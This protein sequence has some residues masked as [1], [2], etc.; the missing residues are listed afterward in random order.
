MSS[1]IIPE[2]P[3]YN[4]NTSDSSQE[5]EKAISKSIRSEINVLGSF[6]NCPNIIRLIAYCFS[7][8]SS[9]DQLCLVYEFAP[10]GDLTEFMKKK[11]KELLWQYR[12]RIAC[13]IAT[14]LNFLHMHDPGY[15]AFHRDIKSSNIVLM[16]D[17]SPK[18]ID[19]G[20]S[21]YAPEGESALGRSLIT[22]STGGNRFGTPAYMCPEYVRNR[23]IKYDAKC[24]FYSF[25]I[26]LLELLSGRQQGLD[27]VY[28]EDVVDELD[29]DKT[30]LANNF[31]NGC[32]AEI[33]EL[34]HCCVEKRATRIS[35]SIDVLRRL[36]C[37]KAKYDDPTYV[38]NV[39]I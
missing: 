6:R 32:I 33:R 4:H 9:S 35:S 19:C 18:I 38:E 36:Q 16:Q 21:K 13:G 17:F 15:P 5:I 22:N 24:E 12:V 28:L 29:V 20:L 25:G 14:G 23:S 26:V 39:I 27:D 10:L 37:I 8:A 1:C 34:A 30:I 11:S 31:P 3:V 2:S 7:N